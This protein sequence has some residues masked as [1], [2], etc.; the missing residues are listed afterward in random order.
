MFAQLSRYSPQMVAAT[1]AQIGK[2]M[3]RVSDLV[4]TKCWNAMMLEDMNFSRLMNHV[5]Q[6]G[7]DKLR[8]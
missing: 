1:K 4:K 5:Q 2:F 8:G 6:V 3:F 7:G